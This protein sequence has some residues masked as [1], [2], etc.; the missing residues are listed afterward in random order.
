MQSIISEIKKSLYIPF[1]ILSCLGVILVCCL[2]EGYRSASGKSY[3]IIE[4]FLFLGKDAMLTDISLN[5]YDIWVQGIGTWTQLLLPFLLSIG[6]L[7]VI[8][9]EK[10][11]GVSRLLLVRQNNFIY[12]I[13]K[14]IAAM[15]NGGIIMLAG[16]LFFGFL[17]Y[18]KFP[19]IYEYSVDKISMYMEVHQGFHEVFFCFKRCMGAFLY[20]M[21]VNGF[22]YL[23]SVFFT[24]KYIVICLPLMLKYIWGQVIMKIE[25][26]AIN[27]GQDT[28]LNLCSGLRAENIFNIN[29]SIYW[30]ITLLLM[31]AIYLAGIC[32]NIYLLKKKG[33]GFG[34][35]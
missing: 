26:D 13:S 12:S 9:N 4:L 8:S 7:Y 1:F 27:N 10:L 30:A 3:T 25:I 19:S 28:V 14:A 34:F 2:S 29:Q 20:G 17:I 18:A 21:C 35:E 31:L 11:A 33:E 6:Y 15:M 32:L 23:V 24:D 22:S 16:Y 5:R